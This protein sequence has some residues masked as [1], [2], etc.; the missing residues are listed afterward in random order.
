M[1]TPNYG[2]SRSPARA[3]LQIGGVSRL[4]SSSI[5]KPPEPL[6]RAVADCLASSAF[7]F[8]ASHGVPSAVVSEAARTLRVSDFLLLFFYLTLI[9]LLN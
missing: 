5:K 4:R 3:R 1:A 9:G 6:R 8:S 7:G 2:L